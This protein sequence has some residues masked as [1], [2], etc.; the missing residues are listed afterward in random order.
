MSRAVQGQPREPGSLDRRRKM[1]WTRHR[2]SAPP[3]LIS[4]DT[5]LARVRG[6]GTS[7]SWAW[8]TR[9]RSRA[10]TA[11][12]SKRD[13]PATAGRLRLLLD[14]EVAVLHERPPNTEPRRRGVELEV[15]P[16]RSSLAEE[17][18]ESHPLF[19]LARSP[20]DRF[21]IGRPFPSSMARRYRPAQACRRHLRLRRCRRVPAPSRPSSR[22]FLRGGAGRQLPATAQVRPTAWRYPSGLLRDRNPC[23]ACA[24]PSPHPRT[25]SHGCRGLA[26]QPGSPTLAARRT[27]PLVQDRFRTATWTRGCP[28]GYR[29]R[30][31]SGERER[32][33][34]PMSRRRSKGQR[35]PRPPRPANVGTTRT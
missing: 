20:A 18:P 14:A 11:T 32:W 25:P 2:T 15:S 9:W 27:T 34:S 10:S 16:S 19:T 31:G 23:R 21:S 8:A 6:A 28:C 30:L 13:R 7:R 12:T 29:C 4:E 24:A 22:S 1:S 3:D 26:Y 17:K 35:R 5:I 33:M